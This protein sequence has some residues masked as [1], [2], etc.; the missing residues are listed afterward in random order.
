MTSR[1]SRGH[2]SERCGALR[3]AFHRESTEKRAEHRHCRRGHARN[4]GRLA[5]GLGAHLQESLH[6]FPG[7]AGDSLE[8]E[9]SWNCAPL[10]TARPLDVCRFLSQVAGVLD[11]GLDTC[12]I[13][14]A[15]VRVEIESQLVTR[16]EIRQPY[17]GLSE[18]LGGRDTI[19][20]S[21]ANQRGLEHREIAGI[22]LAARQERVPASVRNQPKVATRW[23]QAQIRSSSDRVNSL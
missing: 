9:L 2:D 12:E 6:G 17:L 22:P 4:P 1:L 14:I 23:R 16:H 19:A 18:Q 20:S 7:E 15:S 11:G 10:F 5:E 13:Q 21:R 3:P 8:R